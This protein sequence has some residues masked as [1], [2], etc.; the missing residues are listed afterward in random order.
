MGTTTTTT[1]TE[2]VEKAK[3]KKVELSEQ[4]R[5]FANIREEARANHS[6]ETE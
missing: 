2:K 3:A 5:L 6:K 1:T 4:D